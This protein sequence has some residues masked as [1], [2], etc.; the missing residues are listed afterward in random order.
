MNLCNLYWFIL[1]VHVIPCISPQVFNSTVPVKLSP[2]VVSKEGPH[3]CPSNLSIQASSNA[4][5]HQIR[6]AISNIYSHSCRGTGW[7]R[8]AYFNMTQ[9][10]QSCPSSLKYVSSPVRGCARKLTNRFSCDSTT[11]NAPANGYTEVCGTIRAYQ[12]AYTD[13]FWA[14]LGGGQNNID[15]PYIDGISLTYGPAGS[16][17]HIWTFAAA[18]SENDA[19]AHN[20]WNCACTDTRRNWP[21]AIPSFIGNNYFCDTGSSGTTTNGNTYISD[22]LW[23]GK[24]CGLYSTCCQLN[25]PPWFQTTLT[26]YTTADKELRLCNNG[27]SHNSDVVLYFAD[28]YVK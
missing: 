26:Q 22:P 17:R 18:Y 2:V 16:R 1:F 27:N 23:D 7:K 25:N 11:F 24:G 20:S 15:S 14:S 13:A 6:Q 10:G 3:N 28:I 9:N 12:K 5:R 8:V 19:G 4:A 21:Y